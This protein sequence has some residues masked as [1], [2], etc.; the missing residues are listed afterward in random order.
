MTSEELEAIV[1]A[2]VKAALKASQSNPQPLSGGPTIGAVCHEYFASPD[3]RA[4]AEASKPPYKRVLLNWMR[5]QDIGATPIA[6]LTRQDVERHLAAETPGAAGFLLKRVRV[7][8][9]FA[10]A[11]CYIAADPCA[12]IPTPSAGG[13][14]HCWADDEI[15]QFRKVHRLGTRERLAF[16]LVLN[17]ALRRTD[18]AEM[19]WEQIKGGAIRLKQSKTGRVLV[20]PIGDDLASAIDAWRGP[21]TGAVIRHPRRRKGLTAESFG[22]MFAEW[23]DAAGLPARCVLHG[24]RK[25]R[26]RQMAEAGCSEKE[27]S[28]VS[29]H[30]TLQMVAHYTKAADQERLARAALERLR[31][32]AAAGQ[33]ARAK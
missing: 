23:C 19:Q 31:T 8:T 20:I 22:N 28:A 6:L 27:L 32:S 16:E 12:G 5:K 18:A 10:L 24:V 14:W 17:C 30:T 13:T 9:R 21:R 33:P 2:A 7:L 29:G 4:L 11:R 25:G 1:S 15:A 3:Y 26:C